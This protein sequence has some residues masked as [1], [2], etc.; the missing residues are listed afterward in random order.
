MTTKDIL[1]QRIDDAVGLLEC[2]VNSA[3]KMDVARAADAI[4]PVRECV[5]ADSPVAQRLW[6]AERDLRR[7]VDFAPRNYPVCHKDHVGKAAHVARGA[8]GQHLGGGA[9]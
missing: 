3:C 9:K 6:E 7:C 2:A 8:L 4:I 1:E 5:D